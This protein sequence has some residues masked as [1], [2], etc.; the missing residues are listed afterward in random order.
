MD[1]IKKMNTNLPE[2]AEF[3]HFFLDPNRLT[4]NYVDYVSMVFSYDSDEEQPEG[5]AYP[6]FNIIVRAD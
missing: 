4:V 6:G 5:S 1:F 2:G 3:S